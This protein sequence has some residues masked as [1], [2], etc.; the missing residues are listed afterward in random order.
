MTSS[1]L[2]APSERRGSDYARLSRRVAEAGLFA[3]RPVG[4][5][6][7][8][9]LTL[10]GFLAGWAGVVAVGD[11]WVQLLLAVGMA[12]ATTQVAF[13]GH[14]AGHRQMF[15][16]RGPSD[17]AGLIA[18]NLAVGLSYGWW[19]DKHNRHHANPNH[20]DEDPDVGAGA[21]VW[22]YEQAIASRGFGRWLARRQA[23]LFFPMLLLEGLALH[24][25]SVRAL[26]RREP[27]GRWSTPVRHRAVE[28]L[29]L[30]LHAVGYLGLVFAAM[31]PVKALLFV[32]VHQ[33]LW[34]LYMGCS[35]APNHKG[36]PMPTDADDLDFL[37]KQV[38]TSRNVR[39]GRVVDLALGG[40][41]YQVEHHLFPNMPRA[42]LRRAQPIVRA[43]CAERGVPYA[44]TGL[45][46]S[47]RQA[48]AHLHEV[49][50]PLRGK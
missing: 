8:I 10:G 33:G 32:A 45:V 46:E 4:Y 41:N 1:T 43:Y 15:R 13:L 29:L 23:W 6:V 40:L 49:G 2:A 31:S 3:R 14:D 18:A 22:T 7:R 39:G 12:V 37:R 20:S 11:S 42:N 34:G 16:R 30:G 48:L 44:E 50:R 38:L 5:A 9:V 21:L 35:F 17:L 19:I 26:V 28:G 24:V 36:M 25:A 27:D 47:Y